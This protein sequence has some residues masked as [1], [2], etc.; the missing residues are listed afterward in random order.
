[1]RVILDEYVTQ[2]ET[3]AHFAATVGKW[4]AEMRTAGQRAAR[5]Y[6]NEQPRAATAQPKVAFLVHR[7]SSLAHVRLMLDALEGHALLPQPLL[8]PLIVCFRKSL[9]ADLAARIDRLGAEVI[10]IE[11][12]SADEV[13]AADI[14][15]LRQALRTRE[16]D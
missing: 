10:Q 14:E 1:E 8:R 2:T 15:S 11:T 12:V 9:D 5:T 16:A 7:L 4:T 3:E 6:S 13:G